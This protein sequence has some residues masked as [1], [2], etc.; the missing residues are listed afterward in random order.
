MKAVDGSEDIFPRLRA[1]PDGMNDMTVAS[2]VTKNTKKFFELLDIDTMF[3]DEDP[4]TWK[5]SSSYQTG[6]KRV[7]G[8]CVTNDAPECGVARRTKAEDRL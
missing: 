7:E 5:D 1:P 3:F 4:A 6:L 8:L 2:S